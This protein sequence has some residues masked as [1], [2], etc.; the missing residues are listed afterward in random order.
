MSAR[1]ASP[2]PVST[3]LV[4]TGYI[5]ALLIPIAAIAVGVVASRRYVGVGTNHGPVIIGLAVVS[6]FVNFL[7]IM[8][9]SA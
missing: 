1:T 3:G 4:V 5:L 7:I 9:S 6:I 2:K 8:G